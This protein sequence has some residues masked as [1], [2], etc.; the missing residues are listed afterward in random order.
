MISIGYVNRVS[1]AAWDSWLTEL[2]PLWAGKR[3]ADF[4]RTLN[5]YGTVDTAW[6]LSALVQS[7]SVA[8]RGNDYVRGSIPSA[9]KDTELAAL[10][11]S[12]EWITLDALTVATLNDVFEELRQ[13]I[14]TILGCPWRVLNVRSWIAKPQPAHGPYRMHTDGLPKGILK[15]MIYSTP[16]GGEGGGL[17]VDIGDGQTQDIVGP[18][19]TW[20]L[21]YNSRLHHAGIPPTAGERIATEVTLCP[22]PTFELEPV[23]L[24]MNGAIPVLLLLMLWELLNHSEYLS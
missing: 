17:R 1:H 24:D 16:I 10:N 5:V 19:G 2:A 23:S 21:F 22:W 14:A 9:Y 13:T 20:V 8:M 4:E 18:A 3:N 6:L 15:L 12:N 7:Y 11:A